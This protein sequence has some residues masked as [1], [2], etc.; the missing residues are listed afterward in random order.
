MIERLNGVQHPSG[1]L[2]RVVDMDS[3]HWPMLCMA[4]RLAAEVL[5][6]VGN[7]KRSKFGE[8]LFDIL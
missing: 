1:K 6:F 2:L 8:F 5:K 4:D 7:T 3:D